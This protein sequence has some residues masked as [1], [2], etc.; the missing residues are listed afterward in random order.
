M[1][2]VG[3]GRR[4]DRG[5]EAAGVWGAWR[6]C[7]L[8]E[9]VKDVS[10]GSPR[11]W[12]PG[13]GHF[14]EATAVASNKH[15]WQNSGCRAAALLPGSAG[16]LVAAAGSSASDFNAERD[17]DQEAREAPLDWLRVVGAA[18]GAGRAQRGSPRSTLSPHYIV[19]LLRI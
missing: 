12:L 11:L 10:E 1:R 7:G 13:R 3:G 15:A 8:Y 4:G 5:G 6:P 16:R 17:S 19:S 2:C 18:G 14:T 9:A